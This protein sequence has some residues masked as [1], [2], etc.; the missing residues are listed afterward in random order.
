MLHGLIGRVTKAW[1]ISFI[2]ADIETKMDLLGANK[3][4]IWIYN[5]YI[6]FITSAGSGQL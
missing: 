6:G 5:K 4:D 2:K 3:L 1:H